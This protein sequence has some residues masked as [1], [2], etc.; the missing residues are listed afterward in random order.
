MEIALAVQGIKLE[1][2]LREKQYGSA[3]FSGGVFVPGLSAI[4]TVYAR[5][6]QHKHDEIAEN[7]KKSGILK[8]GRTEQKYPI[9][10]MGADVVSETHPIF[11]IRA[12]GDIIFR[13]VTPLE[14]KLLKAQEGWRGKAG[15]NVSGDIRKLIWRWRGTL[16][17]PLAPEV[18]TKRVSERVRQ[19]LERW[20]PV[21]ARRP[22]LS[23]AKK[24]MA[25]TRTNYRRR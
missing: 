7:M 4:R 12:N 2:N 22:A 25:Q 13:K 8:P 15:L 20:K 9:G 19:W 23:Y 17:K 16:R 18:E 21:R 1:S 3:A 6:I 24:P 14:F 5:V 11:S 10:W